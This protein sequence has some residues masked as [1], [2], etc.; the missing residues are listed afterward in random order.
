[1]NARLLLLF[2]SASTEFDGLKGVIV[3]SAP[4]GGF[5]HHNETR[6]PI[7]GRLASF[8]G[9]GKPLICGQTRSEVVGLEFFDSPERIL[10]VGY[11]LFGEVAFL[12]SEGQP[13]ENAHVPTLE[14]HISLLR[15]WIV[16][17]GIPVVEIPPIPWGYKFIACLTHDVDFAGIRHHRFDH[18]FWGFVYRALIGSLVQIVK[19][20]GSLGRLLQNWKAVF[21]LPFVYLGLVEDFW[22]QFHRYADVDQ[23]FAST[24]F[25]IP[26]KDKAGD[27][28]Q[29]PFPQ[30]RA[31][32]YDIGDVHE[33]VERLTQQGYEIGVHGID[34][35]WSEERGRQELNRI[36]EATDQ[37][38]IGVR[39]HWLC[40]DRD[41]PGVLARAGFDYD[42]SFGYNETVGYKAGTPQVFQ[43]LGVT[44][45]LE[46]PLHIQD[47]ALFNPN[48]LGLN[49][50]QAWDLCSSIIDTAAQYGG[51]VTV[52]WHMRSLAP[53]RLWGEFYVR[54]VQELKE[55]GAWFG[56]ANQVVQWFRQRRAVSFEDSTLVDNTLRLR[57]QYAGGGSGPGLCLR[58]H[59]P[60]MAGLSGSCT[61]QAPIDLPWTGEP[62]VAIP[63]R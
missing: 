57:L 58:V 52:L 61:G 38:D 63:L 11:D 14:L 4:S 28:L 49:E 27:N 39:V 33:Q 53:E 21:S 3:D 59:R 62:S 37:K 36:A 19:G 25:L 41:T 30:R 10:R 12:L 15:G 54:L 42:S 60:Q 56:T 46:L 44:R 48:R 18:T 51:V 35:W 26:S 40:F 45:L 9:Q 13:V 16:A 7:Y 8:S 2:S 43:P 20:R 50:T 31:A 34:A 22:D 32:R 6:L 55:R 1:V 23:D 17:A 24:F 5:A 47:T 29:R